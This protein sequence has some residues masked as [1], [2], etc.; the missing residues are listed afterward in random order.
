MRSLR[1]GDAYCVSDQ[2]TQKNQT[3]STGIRCNTWLGRVVPAERFP[4]YSKVYGALTFE[5]FYVHGNA[6]S[7]L[8]KV[9]GLVLAN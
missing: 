4:E 3:Y 5:T 2:L 9:F 8:A 1:I 6:G 7:A